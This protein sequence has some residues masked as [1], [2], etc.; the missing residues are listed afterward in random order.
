MAAKKK[1]V[2]RTFYEIVFR[3]K[4][5]VVR[6]F[7]KGF[8]LGGGDDA[9][10]FYSFT[11]GIWHEGKAEKLKE[12]V[13][14]RGVDCHVVVD[15]QTSAR[16]RKLKRR[17]EDETGL[18][19]TS[20]RAIR[21]ASLEFTY[22]AFSPRHHEEVLAL[23]KQIPDG[24]RLKDFKHEVKVDPDAKGIEAYSPVH[25]FEA[26]GSGVITGRIDLLVDVKKRADAYP[27]FDARDIVLKLA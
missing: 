12:L 5:K 26:T 9:T 25:H 16:L 17:I 18:E 11:D 22:K 2:R 15:A 1:T 13:G 8:V 6:A 20:H 24:L 4:P 27:L 10:V 7:L 3:G 19:I 21:G 14:I 23:A